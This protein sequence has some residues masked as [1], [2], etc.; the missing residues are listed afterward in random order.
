MKIINIIV[1]IIFI[2]VVAVPVFA[3]NPQELAETKNRALA[4]DIMSQ[5]NLGDY[6]DG[7][8]CPE[9]LKWYKM[10][11]EQGQFD[12]RIRIARMYVTGYCSGVE[13]DIVKGYVLYKKI[14]AN[15]TLYP[16]SQSS[17]EQMVLELEKELT[18]E[19]LQKAEQLINTP[20]KF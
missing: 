16:E 12:S 19:Q 13:K 9:A 17:F 20:W 11:A 6:Y 1:G 5:V 18:S 2:L 7:R 3:L 4:G 15:Y 14:L 10:A 8:N